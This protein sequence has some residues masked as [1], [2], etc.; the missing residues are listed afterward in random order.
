[1]HSKGCCLALQDDNAFHQ[2]SR[3]TSLPMLICQRLTRSQAAL[4]RAFVAAN[5]SNLIHQSMTYE[6]V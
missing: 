5:D 4:L 3:L 2:F 6:A 1:M